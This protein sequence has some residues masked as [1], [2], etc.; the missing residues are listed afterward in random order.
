VLTAIP[1][2][3]SITI[4]RFVFAAGVIAVRFP[5]HEQNGKLNKQSRGFGRKCLKDVSEKQKSAPARFVI[6]RPGLFALGES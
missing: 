6:H 2:S 1:V 4:S 3:A 5:K